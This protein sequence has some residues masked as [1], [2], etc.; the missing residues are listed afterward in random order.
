MWSKN[1]TGYIFLIIIISFFLCLSSCTKETNTFRFVFMTD[2][3]V[4]PEK[5][6]DEGFRAAIEKVNQLNPDFVITGGDLIMDALGQ[7]EGRAD[8]LY[9]LYKK[10]LSQLN[11]PVYNTIGNH[12]IFGL[13][14]NSGISPEH[15]E[16]GKQMFR[17]RLGKG[18]TYQSFD[19]KGWH[20]IILD[21]IG[22][23][24]ERHYYGYIDSLQLD[25]LKKDIAKVDQKTP[26]V[27]STHIPFYSIYGQMKNGPTYAMGQGEVITNA[28]DV[29]K[30]LDNHNVKL[31][32]QG[33]LHIVEEIRYG[34]TT[35]ITGG[36]VCAAWWNG[37]RDG[38]PEGFVVIE[39]DK[40]QFSWE[41]MTYGWQA[42]IDAN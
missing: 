28:L 29:M 41:Y 42:V 8:S 22:F 27:L 7:T 39:V 11:M 9:D 12:E 36:A 14:E 10:I 25:W 32:L 13:Y 23:T 30:V 33:H 31:V 1:K 17:N 3:H 26:V 19:H 18:N 16:Y 20:F 2:I 34:N 4:Q 5:K 24:P 15:P 37:P 38:Y 35:Y 6:A 21:G 40:D